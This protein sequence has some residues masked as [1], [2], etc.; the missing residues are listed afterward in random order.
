MELIQQM[1]STD[2]LQLKQMN[3]TPYSGEVVKLRDGGTITYAKEISSRDKVHAIQHNIENAVATE[4]DKSKLQKIELEVKHYWSYGIYGRELFVPKGVMLVGKIHKYPNMNIIAKGDLSVLIEDEIKR[5]Q[6]PYVFVAPA[7]SKRIAFA[8]E[9]TVW[10]MPHRTD[11]V[12]VDK[13]EEFFIADNEKDYL[14]F[15]EEQ[16]TQLALP[17]GN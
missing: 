6:A 1:D 15:V 13:I 8:H 17:L 5:V 12:D 9:D 7:G 4:T 16:K 11:E 10:F 2:L 14:A 3:L